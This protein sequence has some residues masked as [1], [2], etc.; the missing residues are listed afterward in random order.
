M[1]AVSLS[2]LCMEYVGIVDEAAY[3]VVAAGCSLAFKVNLVI[4]IVGIMWVSE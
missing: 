3:P 2:M 1:Y 4:V